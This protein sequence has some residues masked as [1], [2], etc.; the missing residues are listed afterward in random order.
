MRSRPSSIDTAKI[1]A[2]CAAISASFHDQDRGRK[3]VVNIGEL[4][5][6]AGSKVSQQDPAT[7]LII[8]GNY[9]RDS[10]AVSLRPHGLDSAGG[11][12]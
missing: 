9:I 7:T 1:P 4:P 10:C 11:S 5:V 6:L 2:R 12:A 3:L 8:C